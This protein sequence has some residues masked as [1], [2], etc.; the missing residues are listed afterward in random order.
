MTDADTALAVY[1]PER[2]EL[3]KRT[4]AKGAS[5]DEFAFFLAICRRTG[6]DPFT[7]QIYLVPRWDRQARREVRRPQVGID[8]M[9]LVA[10]RS[11]DYAGQTRTEWCGPDGAWFDVWLHRE[12]PAAARVGVYRRG[13]VEALTATALWREYCPVDKEGSPTRQWAQMPALMLAKCAEALAIRRAFPAELSGVYTSEEMAQADTEPPVVP[14]PAPKA[15]P[16]AG[17]RAEDAR[18]LLDPTPVVVVVNDGTLTIRADCG[19]QPVRN[20]AGRIVYKITQDGENIAVLDE[21]VAS[22]IEANRAFK[23][24]TIVRV[25]RSTKT[26]VVAEIVGDIVPEGADDGED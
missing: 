26:P 21:R 4:I 5:D 15:L 8:G 9:R 16:P 10:Q 24:D 11:G 20:H 19:F 17:A 12:P 22:A 2:V 1:T 6:L 3:L 13:F 14:A 18:A 7:N 25:D 23:V